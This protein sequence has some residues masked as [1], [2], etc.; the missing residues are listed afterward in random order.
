MRT[1]RWLVAGGVGVV[2]SVGFASCGGSSTQV[3][4]P[5]SGGELCTPDRRICLEIPAQAIPETQTFRIFFPSTDRPGAQLSEVWDIEAV[6]KD[7]F[8]FLK[9]AVIRVRLDAVDMTQVRDD[10]VL[11]VFTSRDGNWEVLGNLFFDRVRNELRGTTS[12]LSTSALKRAVSAFTVL[13]VDRLPDGGIPMETDAGP[14]P[15]SGVIVIP[16]V[17]DAGRRDAGAGGGSAGGAAAGGSAGGAAGGSAGGAAGGSAGGAAGGSA[18]GAAGGS[19][20]GAAGGSA[21][22]AAGGSAGG[23]AGGSAG[24]AAGGSAGG[25]AGGSAGGAAGGSAGGAAGGSAGGAAGGSA[26]GAAGG[27]AGGAAGGSA[28]GAAGGSAGGAA[29][30]SAGGS[31]AGGSAGGA[32]GGSAGGS[33]AGGSAAGGSA[34]GGSAGGSSGGGSAVDAGDPDGGVDGG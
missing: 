12:V 18:G 8:R 23:A 20:G 15:D 13:R 9:P 4:I 3:T 26:G 22:G 31:A 29:G 30:G 34:A 17:P 11:R 24:G 10:T 14:L 25:A 28:G 19:A 27:S 7:Q 16:P 1:F 32:A 21:G 5:A 2:L 6:D 33:A